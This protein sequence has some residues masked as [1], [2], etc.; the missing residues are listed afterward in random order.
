[1]SFGLYVLRSHDQ[2]ICATQMMQL[3]IVACDWPSEKLALTGC[4]LS[5]GHS[6]RA[7]HCPS[8]LTTGG[9]GDSSAD[10]ES[11][12]QLDLSPSVAAFCEWGGILL[13]LRLDISYMIIAVIHDKYCGDA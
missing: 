12:L 10:L 5:S 11:P 13:R 2:T 1:M 4:Q 6:C 9:G 8:G 3:C 7:L